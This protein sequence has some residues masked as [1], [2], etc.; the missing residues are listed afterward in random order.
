MFSLARRLREAVYAVNLEIFRAACADMT[1]AGMGTTLTG[2][3]LQPQRVVVAQV[4]DSRAYLWRQGRLVQITHDQSLVNQLLDSGQITPDQAKLFEHSNVILQ[5]LGVQEDVEVLVSTE[6]LRRK[7]RIL[8]CSDGLVG[9]VSDEEIAEVMGLSESL[10]DT[11][12][13]L[14]DLA[15]SAGGPDNITVIV[16]EVDGEGLAAPAPED[17]AAYRPL[18]LDPPAYPAVRYEGMDEPGAGAGAAGGGGSG[19]LSLAA[20]LS[21][22]WVIGLLLAGVVVSF[23]LYP[24]KVPGHLPPRGGSCYFVAERP[25][26]DILI[27]EEPRGV[28]NLP[29]VEVRMAPGEHWV[30]LRDRSGP[31]PLL[32]ERQFI[33]VSPGQ[34]C[35][36]RLRAPRPPVAPFPAMP[37]DEEPE[38]P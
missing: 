35:A 16:A 2:L 14:I 1:K 27:D 30:V 37:E 5:A 33:K 10:D 12:R 23:L 3:L 8:L 18:A 24:R 34:R 6:Q 4:G 15:R 29:G 17:V 25:G 36:L 26:L 28:T 20:V 31:V 7:D 22:A 19:P 38:A 13:T 32:G 9:V 11:V 21:M